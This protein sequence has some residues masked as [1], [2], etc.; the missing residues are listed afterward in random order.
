MSANIFNS[1]QFKKPKRNKFNLTH[2]VK[3]STKMGVLTPNLALECIPGDTIDLGADSMVR[4]APMLA[5]IMHKV[6]V[7]Q[8]Y[9][10]VPNRINWK[11]WQDFI[12]SADGAT[13]N[14]FPYIEID[15]TETLEEQKMLDY[16]GVPPFSSAGGST[17]E[18]VSAMPFNA[19]QII[20]NEYYA[21]E[22]LVTPVDTDVVNG[23]NGA[24]KN[25]LLGLRKKAYKHDYF[26]SALPFAQKGNAVDIP[27][28]DVVLKSDWLA[29]S[30][31]STP[32]F[33]QL[34]GGVVPGNL[35]QTPTDI[36]SGA[37]PA[38][39]AYDPD[40]TLETAAT[41]IND[42]RRAFR[43]QEWLEKNAR[44]GTRYTEHILAHFGV[45]SSDARLQRPEYIV[46]SKTPM[47][48]SEVLNAT[49]PTAD[50]ATN[51]WTSAQGTMTGHGITYQ[52]GIN[53]KYFCEEH[54]YI[55]GIMCI[56]PLP[57]YMQGIPRHFKKFDPLDYFYPTF[58]H[59]G[60]QEV[61]GHEIYAY[62]AQSESTFGYAP[63]Y[64][65]YKYQQNRVAGDFRT[66]LK[67]WTLVREFSTDPSL[68][69]SFLEIDSDVQNR[70]FAVESEEDN[71]WIQTLHK[72]HAIRPMAVYGSPT[73]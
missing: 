62:T 17:P 48:I 14:P 73:I 28:G 50:P 36:I 43:L 31:T 18:Q 61:K 1:V 49:G 44:G 5:P 11:N 13:T 2:D 25:E 32:D 42:L 8:H 72:I 65:E 15:G 67:F 56:M 40:G 37:S 58:Q 52:S 41:T 22:N 63:R 39:T 38:S 10:F 24:I 6:E 9:F 64:S 4:F 30:S 29:G 51:S 3:Y 68:N 46:G 55:I 69:Q 33:I 53:K 59:I 16:M 45:R 35:Q 47:M 54:G 66:T 70:A 34:G 12:V 20:Y 19:F 26:T 57:A 23:N 7:I 21:D 71:C 27:L 60:E